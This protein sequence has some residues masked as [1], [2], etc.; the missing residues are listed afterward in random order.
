MEVWKVVFQNYQRRRQ[1]GGKRRVI[2]GRKKRRGKIR[3]REELE[4]QVIR[5][6]KKK[7]SSRTL[8][9][10]EK[11]YS[12]KACRDKRNARLQDLM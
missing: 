3:I 5:Q 8:R 6:M 2:K 4:E 11:N 1:K 9:I 7:E 10:L 12:R